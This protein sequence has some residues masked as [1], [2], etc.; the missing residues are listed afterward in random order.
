MLFRSMMIVIV[1]GIG[2]YYFTGDGTTPAYGITDMP[3]LFRTAKT[4]HLKG[5]LYRPGR[6]TPDGNDVLPVNWNS[7]PT[8]KMAKSGIPQAA[9]PAEAMPPQLRLES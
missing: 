6:K 7:G 4:I 5:W 8:W 1:V 2:M 3:E 9:H